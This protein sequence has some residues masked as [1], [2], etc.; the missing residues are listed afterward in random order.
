V[1][2]EVSTVLD[3]ITVSLEASADTLAGDTTPEEVN[4]FTSAP[5]GL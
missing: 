3:R 4:G 1:R 5:G 2:D